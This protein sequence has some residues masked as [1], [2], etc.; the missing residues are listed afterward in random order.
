MLILKRAM[1][2]ETGKQA[3]VTYVRSVLLA[4]E[5]RQSFLNMAHGQVCRGLLSPC[6]K[7]SPC[8][9]AHRL[10]TRTRGMR[11]PCAVASL[12]QYPAAAPLMTFLVT[13]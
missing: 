3:A 7:G 11:M 5:T 9:H 1:E 12:L 13:V 6:A 4:E 8:A 2:D 10:Y